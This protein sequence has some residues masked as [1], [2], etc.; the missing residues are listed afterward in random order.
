ERCA[1]EDCDV[2]FEVVVEDDFEEEPHPA[3][4]IERPTT[5]SRA[6]V[7]VMILMMSDR[8]LPFPTIGAP[9]LL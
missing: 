6:S 5:A 1:A 4:E 7:L 2:V 3:T 8:A 9:D